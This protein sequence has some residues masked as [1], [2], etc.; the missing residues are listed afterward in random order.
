M[1]DMG[2]NQH[3]DD[4]PEPDL[5]LVGMS[6]E[7]ERLSDEKDELVKE[8]KDCEDFFKE[9]H[10]LN[11]NTKERILSEYD[12]KIENCSEL[13]RAISERLCELGYSA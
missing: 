1:E 6:E 9:L 10:Y 12:D 2:Y 11:N 4:L 13:H 3:G 7:C 8:K 5:K